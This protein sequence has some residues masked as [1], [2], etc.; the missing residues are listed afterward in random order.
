MSELRLA[1]TLL[2]VALTSPALALAQHEH[3][4]AHEE[5]AP[6]SAI[7]EH[8]GHDSAAHD[9]AAP[10]DH[11]GHAATHPALPPITDEARAAAFPDL[12]DMRMDHMMPG[13]PL[14]RFVLLDQLE[15]H[16]GDGEPLAYELDAWVGHDLTK[17][18]I[19]GQGE[20]RDGETD[21][22]DIQLL[23]GKGFSR[24]WT[25][26]AGAR[27]DLE[28]S[29]SANWAAIGVR[30]L[31]PYR[32]DIAA[33]AFVGE[34]SRTAFR[35]EAEHDILITN[36][37]ILQPELEVDWYGATDRARGIGAGLSSAEIGL[38]LRYEFRRQIAP[39]IGLFRERAFGATA[40]LARGDG[41]G[42]DT[43]VIAGIRLWF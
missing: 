42:D 9:A 27:H 36:R 3:H 18:W 30:G 5:H 14:N 6:P 13:D 11:A 16:D 37:L 4:G 39:Y 23:W 38:R 21:R 1:R 32:F 35:F 8:A 31:A 25:F 40:D 22:A 41:D 2:A 33:T 19:R 29:P 24:W 28:P 34:G 20:E 43:S 12:G 15:R 10:P 7:D 17:L 26:L